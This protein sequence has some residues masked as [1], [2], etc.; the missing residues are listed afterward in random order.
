MILI[1]KAIVLIYVIYKLKF[2]IFLFIKQNWSI[3]QNSQLG[4]QFNFHLRRILWFKQK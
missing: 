2:W 1:I 4:F 3:K